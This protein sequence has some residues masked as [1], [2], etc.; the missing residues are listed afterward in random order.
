M[1]RDLYVGIDLAIA[2]NKR[3][4]VCVAENKLGRFDVLPLRKEIDP[5]LFPK[6]S[7]NRAFLSKSVRGQFVEATIRLFVEIEAKFSGRIRVIAIDA[8]RAPANNSD[9]RECERELNRRNWSCFSTPTAS[10]FCQIS[11]A[12]TTT[13][14]KGDQNNACLMQI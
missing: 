10:K 5:S 4:P 12:A 1:G 2:K 8:P 3:L 7:G 6:G 9:G 11:K 14:P 13:S